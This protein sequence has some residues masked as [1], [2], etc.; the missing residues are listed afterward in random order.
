VIPP[1]PDELAWLARLA[2]RFDVELSP[3]AAHVFDELAATAYGGLRYADIGERA[4]LG[5]RT[6]ARPVEIPATPEPLTAGGGPLQLVRYRA[7]FSGPAVERV[8]E[9]Q[10]QRPEPVIELSPDDAAVRGI[11]PGDTVRVS[12]NGTS[13]ELR[14]RINRALRAGVV[15]AAEEH[16]RELRAGVEITRAPEDREVFR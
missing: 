15:R 12:S 4:E 8:H 10:F 5:S 2:E 11:G 13:V 7:L 6:P 3:H 14:A 16:V 9:L 1:A